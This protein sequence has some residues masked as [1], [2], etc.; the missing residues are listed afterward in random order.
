[1]A[2]PAEVA[3]YV[4]AAA[5]LPQILSLIYK[6]IVI[7]KVTII[8]EKKV[9]IGYTAFGPIFN[10][11]LA[12][13]AARKEAVIDYVGASIRHKDGSEHKLEWHG[14]RETFSQIIDPSGKMG[15]IERDY[16]PI[17]LVLARFGVIERHFRFQDPAF[18]A[19]EQVGVRAAVDHQAFLK[20]K[21]ADYHQELLESKEVHNILDLYQQSFFWKAGKYTLRF[22]VKSPNKLSLTDSKYL[23]ELKSYEVEVLKKNLS[24]FRTVMSNQFKSDIEGFKPEDIRWN[25]IYANVERIE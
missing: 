21:K 12:I 14:M 19:K 16:S 17:A 6:T 18:H 4:G 9:E 8:P 3:A 5:W 7:P 13:S 15:F 22:F 23:F 1:M 2:T 11:R 24:H 10:L 25:W 20:S